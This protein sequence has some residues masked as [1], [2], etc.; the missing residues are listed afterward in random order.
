MRHLNEEYIHR[1]RSSSISRIKKDIPYIHFSCSGNQT[2][3][4]INEL[5]M[6][7]SIF[8]NI[9]EYSTDLV[10]WNPIDLSGNMYYNEITTYISFDNDLWIRGK[11]R[12]GI[13]YTN[14]KTKYSNLGFCFQKET[15]VYIEG[16]IRTLIDW[17]N[18]QTCDTSKAEFSYMFCGSKYIRDASRLLLGIENPKIGCYISMF[19]ECEDLKYPP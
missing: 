2:L 10:N 18:Y 16:D 1:Q 19:Q 14:K 13:C 11:S 9:F 17:E 7:K 5:N 15:F 12:Y 8:K 4:I 6:P 3:Y